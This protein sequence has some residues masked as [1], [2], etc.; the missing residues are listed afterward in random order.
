MAE[1]PKQKS[2]STGKIDRRTFLGAAA[3]SA[4]MIFIK[5]ALVRGTAANS[6]VRVG[7]LGCGGRGTGDATHLVETGGARGVAF[8][9]IFQDQVD[10]GR[11]DLAPPQHGK[12]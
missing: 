12:G 7:L 6:A 3:A 8:A 2:D 9:D 5:P 1:D 4:G 10:K 11:A